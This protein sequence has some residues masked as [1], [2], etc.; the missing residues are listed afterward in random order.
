MTDTPSKQL[1]I[2]TRSLLVREINLLVTATAEIEAQS[3]GS[4][5]FAVEADFYRLLAVNC[6]ER[7]RMAE[8]FM[9]QVKEGFGD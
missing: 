5:F 7:A 9:R 2:D 1:G 8:T 6:D 3:T 4:D